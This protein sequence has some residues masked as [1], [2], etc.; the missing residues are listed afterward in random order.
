MKK[1]ALLCASTAMVM[2]G[3]AFAQS[4]GS[5]D[6]ENANTVVVTGTRTQSVG[7]VEVPDTS[8]TREV[9]NA[10]FIQRQTPGQRST[11]RS[12]SSA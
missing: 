9:L 7:G 2:P 8:K 5:V 6:F 3:V 10:E 4:T 12:T 1:I 11:R